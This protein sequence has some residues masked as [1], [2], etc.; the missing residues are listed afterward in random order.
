MRTTIRIDDELYRTLKERA[1]R[2]GR[3]VSVLLEDALRLGLSRREHPGAPT[4]V[5]RP[6]GSGGLRPGIDLA[7]NVTI[8]E[9]LD[10]DTGLDAL[11]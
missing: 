2:S 9:A 8:Y 7:S 6:T 11:R 3:T 10:A 4:F 1:A 5:I